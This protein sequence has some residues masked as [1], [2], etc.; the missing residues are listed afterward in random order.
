MGV[1]HCPNRDRAE[2]WP[3]Q[4]VPSVGN[5]ELRAILRKEVFPEFV[6]IEF[7]RIMKVVFAT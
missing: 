5:S 4:R 3:L 2:P 1:D 6:E 7:E